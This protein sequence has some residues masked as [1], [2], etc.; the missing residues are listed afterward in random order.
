MKI[1]NLLFFIILGL[2]VFSTAF[3]QD[4]DST[5]THHH[6]WFNWDRDSDLFDISIHG[7]PTLSFNYGLSKIKLKNSR[8]NL[9]ILNCLNL[10]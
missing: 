7:D 6:N 9:L 2:F 3:A 1:K 10:K 5:E 4:D 8:I